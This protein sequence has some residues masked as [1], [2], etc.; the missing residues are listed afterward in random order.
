MDDAG[1]RRGLELFNRGEF[2][3]AH[4]VLEDVWRAAPS[5]EKLFLQG[6]IQLAVGL[7][8]YTTGNLIGACSLLARGNQN[9][10]K[11]PRVFGGI[12]LEQLRT[13]ADECRQVL[14]GA[15]QLEKFPRIQTADSD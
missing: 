1:Y 11:Y 5:E 14:L 7:H 4:E 3:D 12:K 10:G 6:L 9:L 2:F 15:G 8:H 13:A